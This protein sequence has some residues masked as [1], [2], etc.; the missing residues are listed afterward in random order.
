MARVLKYRA[1]HVFNAAV[2]DALR[3]VTEN[4]SESDERVAQLKK[5]Y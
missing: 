1:C 3:K 2:E 4:H 5:K